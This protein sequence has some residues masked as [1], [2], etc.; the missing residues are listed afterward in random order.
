MVVHRDT[1]RI[2]TLA[3]FERSVLAMES[4]VWVLFWVAMQHPEIRPPAV[5]LLAHG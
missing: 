5:V 1:R 4:I 3:A 2:E